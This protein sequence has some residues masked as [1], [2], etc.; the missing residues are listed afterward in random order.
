MYINLNQPRYL[1]YL[2]TDRHLFRDF[3]HCSFIR[4]HWVGCC[5][6]PSPAR[7]SLVSPPP[8]PFQAGEP[9]S[10]LPSQPASPLPAAPPMLP[11]PPPRPPHLLG[12]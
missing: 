1:A 8:P 4:Y 3:V 9:A 2:I 12:I 7:P 10:Y 11:L 5:T 6:L